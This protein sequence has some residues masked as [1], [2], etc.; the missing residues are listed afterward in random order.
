MYVSECSVGHTK[1][2]FHFVIIL[3][4]RSRVRM[5][6]SPTPF[7][8][9]IACCPAR[10][11]QSSPTDEFALRGAPRATRRGGCSYWT[12]PSRERRKP[13]LSARTIGREPRWLLAGMWATRVML[14]SLALIRAPAQGG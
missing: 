10:T 6:L 3:G 11:L 13:L 7:P 9:L 2:G 4:R 1:A 14:A 5:L 8:P 12:R